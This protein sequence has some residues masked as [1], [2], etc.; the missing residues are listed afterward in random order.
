VASNQPR[1]Q[2]YIGSN[3]ARVK[4]RFLGS[5]MYIAIL[6]SV[7]SLALFVSVHVC[8]KSMSNDKICLKNYLLD[9]LA[10]CHS[11]HRIAFARETEDLGSN[12]STMYG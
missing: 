12:P 4:E 8:V 5:Y 2:I 3:P 9:A 10:A 6:V 1:E 7:T 11:D